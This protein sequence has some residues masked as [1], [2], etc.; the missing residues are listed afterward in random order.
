MRHIRHSLNQTARSKLASAFD[1]QEQEQKAATGKFIFTPPADDGP[2][3]HWEV[4]R[5]LISMDFKLKAS[6]YSYLTH[7]PRYKIMKDNTESPQETDTENEGGNGS[8]NENEN[9]SGDGNGNR[10]SNKRKI[11]TRSS[12]A[13]SSASSSSS[14]LGDSGDKPNPRKRK[15]RVNVEIGTMSCIQ[16]LIDLADNYPQD[17]SVKYSVDLTRIHNIAKPLR[18]L[19]AM[20]GLNDL[21]KTLVDQILYFAQDLHKSP[22]GTD[23]MDYMH[24]VLYGPPGTGKTEV[25]MLMAKIY[26]SLGILKKGTFSK[27]TRSDLIAGYLGQTALKT[28]KVIEK[29][30]DGVLFIDEAYSLGNSEKRDSF[31]QECIDTICESASHYKDRI[32]III[33]GYE[34][35]LKKRFF[36]WNDGLESRFPWRHQT[37]EYNA[38]ELAHIFKKKV[39]DARWACLLRNEILE[40]W[41]KKNYDDFGFYGRDVE[42][43]FSKVKIAHAHRI[44]G[45]KRYGKRY[46]TI[47]DIDE[48][49][50]TFKSN[51]NEDKS[52]KLPDDILATIYT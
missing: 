30:L 45:K 21:K 43:L 28:K 39:H 52:H 13:S 48:G 12:R 16:D 19:N 11:R 14:T 7:K 20:V 17:E 5:E 24:T 49:L 41:F 6:Y 35:E 18:E 4:Y 51:K 42:T 36:A 1:E 25:A 9:R 38:G 37:S 50:K 8:E 29:A 44:F 46:V 27:V 15:R 31:A 40:A 34:E 2:W 10:G 47:E 26:S 33:A 23:T 22:G 3:E 32:V